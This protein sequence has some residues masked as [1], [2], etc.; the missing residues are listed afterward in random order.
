MKNEKY[1]EKWM[2]FCLTSH[3]YPV[4]LVFIFIFYYNNTGS[5]SYPMCPY[6]SERMPLGIKVLCNSYNAQCSSGLSE[7]TFV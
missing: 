6:S 2:A 4:R 5:L 7:P 3:Q 1:G